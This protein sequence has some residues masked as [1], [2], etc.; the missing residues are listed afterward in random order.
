MFRHI[1]LL[2]AVGCVLG[3]LD[4]KKRIKSKHLELWDTFSAV[5]G[6]TRRGKEQ[7]LPAS[8]VNI[9]ER[10]MKEEGKLDRATENELNKRLSRFVMEELERLYAMERR[11]Q[12]LR[13]KNKC[14]H[15]ARE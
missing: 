10:A 9:F 2:I 12:I 3:D 11:N 13:L 1:I 8:V 14:K 6:R 15:R 4:E 7:K 5:L